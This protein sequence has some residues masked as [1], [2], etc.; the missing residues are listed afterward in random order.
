M[1]R[2]GAGACPVRGHS[3]VQGDRTVGITDRPGPA[4]LDRLD[5][6][7]DFEPPREHGLDTVHAIKAMHDG[8][9]CVFFGMGGN[10]LSATPDTDYTAD[11]LRNCRLTVHVS[12]K[13]N[14][15]HL[16]TGEEALILPCLG[17]TERDVQ[18][19]G[20]QFVT[21]EN[22]MGIVH[23]SR[24]SLMPASDDLLSEPMIVARLA[25]ATFGR[26][27]PIPWLKMAGDYDQI[28]DAIADVVPGFEDYNRRVRSENGF[29]LPNGAR[30]RQFN[31][32]DGKAH[33]TVHPVP[34]LDLE[35]GELLMMTLRSHD[36]YNTTIYSPDDR[37]R[38]IKNGRRV[39]FLNP[40]DV[41]RLGLSQGQ[42]V[43]LVSHF[44]GEERIARNFRVVSYDMPLRSAATYFP[45][46]NVLVPVDS[47]A[48]RSHTPTSKSVVITIRPQR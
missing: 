15:A 22:S 24:G 30:D 11:A 17:R 29:V 28:R 21:V 23:S 37:Y 26:D 35:D 18:A 9:A 2:P 44:Q 25:A 1:G 39:V 19:G 46:A 40:A 36:Q 8:E 4:F 38:G 43:D 3:N 33:F 16:V 31:T 42:L 32:S 47:Y 48:D 45:E 20:P 41:A 10:F 12:T 6:R 13:L 14:R 34:E 27:H 7:F 5:A